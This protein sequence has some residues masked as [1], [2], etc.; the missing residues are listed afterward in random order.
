MDYNAK[1]F[2]SFFMLKIITSSF[3]CLL[4]VLFILKRFGMPSFICRSKLVTKQNFAY[5]LCSKKYYSEE[6]FCLLYFVF[7]FK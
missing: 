2:D 4:T 6:E 3:K 5:I 7:I 1:K